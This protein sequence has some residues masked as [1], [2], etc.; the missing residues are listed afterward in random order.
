LLIFFFGL[1]L[2][3]CD[4]S[5]SAQAQRYHDKMSEICVSRGLD[6]LGPFKLPSKFAPDFHTQL[7]T[8]VDL[9]LPVISFTFGALTKDQI[10]AFKK[11]KQDTIVMGTA[12]TVEEALE[13]EAN[14][15]D[16]IVAQGAEVSNAGSL[17]LFYFV[18]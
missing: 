1:I 12:T 2:I 6:P 15:V 16:A 3:F 13:L 14:G 4:F 11:R 17:L 7:Q 18:N 5:P 10:A 9:E 8:L